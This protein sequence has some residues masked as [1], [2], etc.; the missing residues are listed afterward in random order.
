MT[1]RKTNSLQLAP[2]ILMKCLFLTLAK[3]YI[4]L[5]K[6]YMLQN[7]TL[8]ARYSHRLVRAKAMTVTCSVSDTLPVQRLPRPMKL[9]RLGPRLAVKLE[10][11]QIFLAP[12]LRLTK[13]LQF[14][15]MFL[16]PNQ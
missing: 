5:A 9:T 3:R 2:S 12:T 13:V 15:S 6:R 10:I 16:D 14:P 1:S 8:L 7:L 11:F 4:T